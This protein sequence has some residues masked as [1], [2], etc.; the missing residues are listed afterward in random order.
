MRGFKVRLAT[1]A[2][3]LLSAGVIAS[4]MSVRAQTAA[5]PAPDPDA[6][7]ATTI[8][9]MRSINTAEA[10]FRHNYGHFGTM[11]DLFD[12][13]KY[14]RRDPSR[15]ADVTKTLGLGSTDG[16]PNIWISLI[17]SPREDSYAVGV[18]DKLK[19]DNGFAAFSDPAGIIYIGQ[20]LGTPGITM[21]PAVDHSALIN[22][23]R[24]VNT[25][26]VSYH[27][28]YGRFEEWKALSDEGLLNGY[29][30]L[31]NVSFTPDPEV[32]PDVN[33]T[34]AVP[35]TYDTWA[36]A[37]HDNAKDHGLYSVFSDASGIIYQTKPLQ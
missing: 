11:D 35:A 14:L 4:A 12:V 5:T 19:D 37:I 6:T 34:V 17:L 24:T 36:V 31:H 32:L 28:K 25:A 13:A 30:K 23:M 22:L 27:W 26:E 8:G 20:P 7:R 16:L 15:Y 1:I 29:A 21:D 3:V 2:T 33:V 10:T 18:Y 9:L